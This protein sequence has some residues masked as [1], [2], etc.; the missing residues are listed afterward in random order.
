M[1]KIDSLIK[2][3]YQKEKKRE[4]TLLKLIMEF[5]K[6]SRNIC[7]HKTW[8][9]PIHK[10][11]QLIIDKNLLTFMIAPHVKPLPKAAKTTVS[12]VLIFPFLPGFS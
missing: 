10:M 2:K 1:N 6:I 3:I 7:H 4:R 8:N 9:I 11:I 12:P 5:Y